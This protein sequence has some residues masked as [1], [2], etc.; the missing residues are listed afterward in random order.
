MQP[1]T[2]EPKV[3]I[4]FPWR[5]LWLFVI[6]WIAL[7]AFALLSYNRFHLTEPDQAYTWTSQIRGMLPIVWKSFADLHARF[8]S[9]FYTWI[10]AQGYT[11]DNAAFLPFYPLL[12]RAVVTTIGCK[13]LQFASPDCYVTAAF[14]VS[15]LSA[16]AAALVLYTLAQLDVDQAAAERAVFYFLIFPSAFFL[17]A[18][19]TESLFVLLS[20]ASLYM[21]RRNHW[22]IAS[23]FGALAMLTR[24]SG[25]ALFAALLVEG[26][27]QRRFVGWLWTL[28]MPLAFIIF[29]GYL[30]AQGLSFFQ[31]Q[32]V[33]FNRVPLQLEAW[34]RQLDWQHLQAQ[35]AAQVN[36]A[37]DVGL[38]LFVLLMSL[39]S[40][41]RLR[42]SYGV[43]GA[44]CVLLPLLTIQTLSLN[45]Y[46]LVAFNVPVMLSLYGQQVWLDRAYTLGAI[47]L[48]ALYTI[49]FTQG[50]W[51]G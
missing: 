14:L 25:I 22:A 35:P 49:L 42:F 9:G 39:I 21:A 18:N 43:F 2:D 28:L 26:G 6:W 16:L 44:L 45:R 50:Y 27:T 12:I 34:E 17:T 41:W 47:L 11:A 32:Q 30:T 29:Q 33:L 4:N 7:Q 5:V 23:S 20:A 19:Y 10:A 36:F 31:T 48:L 3:S 8:D 46:A 37:L 38:A 13:P 40:L 24:P 1:S 15:N 51:A